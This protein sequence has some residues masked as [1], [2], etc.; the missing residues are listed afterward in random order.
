MNRITVRLTNGKTFRNPEHGTNLGT[1]RRTECHDG[2]RGEKIDDQVT[3]SFETNDSNT[4]ILES[5]VA[6][7]S[8]PH[9]QPP[10]GTATAKNGPPGAM[11]TAVRAEPYVR[12][13]TIH[14][15]EGGRAITYE[16][17]N[18]MHIGIVEMTTGKVLLTI[19]RLSVVAQRDRKYF[20]SE[21]IGPHH[22][23]RDALGLWSPKFYD[24]AQLGALVRLM[25]PTQLSAIPRKERP[26]GH[27]SVRKVTHPNVRLASLKDVRATVRHYSV[28]SGSGFLTIKDLYGATCDAYVE[29]STVKK[30]PKEAFRPDMFVELIAGQEVI[31]GILKPTPEENAPY[32]ALGVYPAAGAP[33]STIPSPA[34]SADE[35]AGAKP[36]QNPPT[37]NMPPAPKAALSDFK[38]SL[39]KAGE[40]E[41]L[42]TRLRMKTT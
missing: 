32:Q 42:K 3:I 34:E 31:I 40:A 29:W 25:T 36:A 22:L 8:P 26:A 35:S 24:T 6:N 41:T 11:Y 23:H 1:V 20:A 5:A 10:P 7:D 28:A 14:S 13:V 21:M 33:N 16:D 15:H 9:P 2:I 27:G 37:K 4:F 19:R 39:F 38:N 17:Q 18:G 12:T 30:G